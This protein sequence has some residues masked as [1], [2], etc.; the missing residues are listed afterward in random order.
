MLVIKHEM[1]ESQ[2]PLKRFTF[3]LNSKSLN[4]QRVPLLHEQAELALSNCHEVHGEFRPFPV[5]HPHDG[6]SLHPSLIVSTLE[7][8]S[9]SHA[10]AAPSRNVDPRIDA[11]T[12][13]GFFEPLRLHLFGFIVILYLRF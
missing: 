6:Q 5:A 13:C 9:L 3:T 8:A 7:A 10:S 1:L 2:Y 11:R 12:I 4:P